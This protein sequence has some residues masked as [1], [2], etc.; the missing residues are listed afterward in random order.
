VAN[1]AKRDTTINDLN[2]AKLL[3]QQELAE[4][5]QQHKEV[6]MQL[7]GLQAEHSALQGRQAAVEGDLIKAQAEVAQ[8]RPWDDCIPAP[9]FVGL[10]SLSSEVLLTLHPLCHHHT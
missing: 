4:L 7:A 5:Q 6:Q 3:V 9:V 2:E 10:I 8:V 1:L